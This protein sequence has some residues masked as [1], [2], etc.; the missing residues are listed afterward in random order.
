MN[1]IK[2]VT[3][4]AFTLIE[5]IAVITIIAILMSITIP[6]INKYIDRANETKI[7]SIV[8]NLN[9]NLIFMQS[10]NSKEIS[11]T[12]VIDNIGK[13]NLG[14]KINGNNFEL[15]KY[16]GSFLIENERVI[17]EIIKPKKVKFTIS[18]KKEY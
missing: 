15:G 10:E 1:K 12:D 14:I 16:Q 17:A 5:I 8:S 4:K 13:D 7:L 9:N 18:G 2:K 6:S 3:N 11:I